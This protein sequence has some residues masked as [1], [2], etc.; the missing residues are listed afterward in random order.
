[1]KPRNGKVSSQVQ[2][3]AATCP[4]VAKRKT[5]CAHDDASTGARCPYKY[6]ETK[7]YRTHIRV[8]HS[9][10]I[11]NIILASA[12][13]PAARAQSPTEGPIQ[14]HEIVAALP[15]EGI[16]IGAL[17]KLFNKTRVGDDGQPTTKKEF[18]RLVKENSAYGPDKLLRPK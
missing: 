18:I 14:P 2:M 7:N 11:T 15:A 8:K 5:Q 10:L 6:L 12:T 17:M 16:S 13:S 3:Q 1:L 4:T 9:T